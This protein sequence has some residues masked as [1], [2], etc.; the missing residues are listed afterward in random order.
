V[1]R[2]FTQIPPRDRY[3]LPPAIAAVKSKAFDWSTRL[4]LEIVRQ[5][6][7]TDDVPAVTDA[8][9]ELY[10]STAIEAAELYTGLLLSGQRMITEPAQGPAEPRPG[11]ASYKH[12]LQYPVADGIVYLYGGWHPADNTVFRVPIGTRTIQIP[13]RTGWIDT[14]NCCDPCSSHHMNADMMVGYQAGFH[15][16]DDVP[17]GIV[18]GCLQYIAWTVEHPGDEYLS[19]RNTEVNRAGVAQGSSNIAVASG[20]LETW[21]QYDSEAI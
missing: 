9:L 14:S 21:R 12:R 6:T 2:T 19:V 4:S 7:K 16:V 5:H 11:K 18:L 10:R 1:L 20:A 17:S 3:A 13:I 15:C 8:Q